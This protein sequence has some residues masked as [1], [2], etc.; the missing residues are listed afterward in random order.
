[1]KRRYQL[2]GASCALLVGLGL[3][4]CKTAATFAPDL[5]V[6]QVSPVAL[7]SVQ[8]RVFDT[9]DRA[10]T[11]QTVIATMQDLGFVIDKADE[12]T[13]IV[14]GTKLDDYILRMS[15][16]VRPR[17]DTQMVVR[18]SAQIQHRAGARPVRR[19]IGEA[20]PYQRFFAALEQAMFLAAHEAKP[21][22]K[23]ARQGGIGPAP[24]AGGAGYGPQGRYRP[25]LPVGWRPAAVR[26]AI[27]PRTAQPPVSGPRTPVYDCGGVDDCDIDVTYGDAPGIILDHEDA[28]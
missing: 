27:A 14:S 22:P 17:G 15:V 21:S 28:E 7:R 20:L 2:A 6:R 11:V 10:A 5:M 4:G 19:G 26:Q 13:G 3:T 8:S 1:M 18:A 9:A 12:P 24:V 16:N 23:M 25:A